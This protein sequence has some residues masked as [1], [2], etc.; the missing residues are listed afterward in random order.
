MIMSLVKPPASVGPL[1]RIGDYLF[2]AR[3]PGLFLW[4]TRRTTFPYESTVTRGPPY[5]LFHR[6]GFGGCA[7]THLKGTEPVPPFLAILTRTPWVVVTV[8]ALV[9][10]ARL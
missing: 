4:I 1:S 2:A 7:A 3:G 9:L 8:P 10:C 5:P 6:R